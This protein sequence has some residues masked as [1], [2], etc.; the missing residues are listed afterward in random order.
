MKPFLHHL[1]LMFYSQYILFCCRL[2]G[3]YYP[4]PGNRVDVYR[5]SDQPARSYAFF[6]LDVLTFYPLIVTRLYE[7]QRW[8]RLA[9]WSTAGKPRV[10]KCEHMN[11]VSFDASVFVRVVD[12]ELS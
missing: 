2:P 9:G 10:G 3:T 5:M 11:G 12:P 4:T 6:L 1:N 7:Y 8:T